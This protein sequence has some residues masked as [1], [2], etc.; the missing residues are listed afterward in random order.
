MSPVPI[1]AMPIP[2]MIVFT[3]GEVEVDQPRNEDEIPKYPG[4]PAGARRPPSQNASLSVVLLSMIV[5]SRSLG[6][7]MTVST[8]SRSAASPRSACAPLL[9]FELER[10]GDHGDRERAQLA[11]EAGDD[12]RRAGAGAAAEPVVTNTMS[13]PSSAW[14]SCRCPPAR[15]RAR[16]WDRRPRPALGQLAAD[17]ILLGARCAQRLQ[18]VLATMNSTPSEAH[19]HHAVDGVAAAAAARRPL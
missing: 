17:L 12:R 1:I 16:R 11:R 15:P 13:A 18:S 5:S 2:D 8:H 4:S 9:A 10:L 7:V 6:I 3:S 14:I 19:L